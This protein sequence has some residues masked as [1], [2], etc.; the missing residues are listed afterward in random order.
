[1]ERSSLLQ[2]HVDAP[3]E[4]VWDLLGDPNRHP[5]WWPAWVEVECADIEQGCRYR[6]V[7][8]GPM[9]A[10]EHEVLLERLDECREISIHCEGTGV[11]TRFRLTEARGGTFVEGHFGAQP[12]SIGMKVFAAVAG[13]R[14]MR[15]WLQRSLAA[16]KA[17]A[18]R[19]GAA[20]PG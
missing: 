2:T 13:R 11:Y 4:V 19:S 9:G 6:A 20:A 10:E 18:E 14:Y 3:V 15:S 12:E 1:M 17:A 5:E 7:I 8:K 16:L